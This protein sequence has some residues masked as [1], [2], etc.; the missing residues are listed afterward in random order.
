MGYSIGPKISIDGE[1]EF[2]KQIRDINAVYKALEAET[3]AV[4][5]AFEANGNEQG[6]LESQSKQLTKMID[7]QKDKLKHLEDAV[8][9]AN[10]KYDESSV[11]ATR[12]RGA[13]YDT[14]ATIAKLESELTDTDQKLEAMAKGLDLVGDEADS[15]GDK[16]LDFSDILNANL[17][18]DV[19]TDLLQG[20]ADAVGDF[21]KGSLDAASDVK[22]AG[23]QFSQ[24]FGELE[25]TAKS[26]LESISGDTKIA[27]TRLQGDFTTLYAFTKNVGADSEEALDIAGRA[28]LAAAD[29]AAYYDKSIEEATEQL[30]SFLKGNYENDAALGIAATETARNTKANELYAMSFNDLSEAQKVDVLLAMVEAGN[31]AS[32]ALG[33]A[34]REAEEFTLYINQNGYFYGAFGFKTSSLYGT[35]IL[36]GYALSATQYKLFD[37]VW[38]SVALV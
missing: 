16:V 37:G 24:T 18:S 33:M 35:A 25:S 2:R 31:Q 20:A 6:K 14:Q 26:T 5:S 1:A 30:Q 10:A 34:A 17:V 29:N 9:K 15:A 23:S 4:T 19:A 36:F 27:V 12:L 32:G 11:E 8:S 3:R 22:A 21:A 7:N 28:M 13:M 38:S